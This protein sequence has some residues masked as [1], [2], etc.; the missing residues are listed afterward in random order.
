MTKMKPKIAQTRAA[1][2]R[3]PIEGLFKCDGWPLPG[4]G[5]ERKRDVEA[6]LEIGRHGH[7]ALDN[8]KV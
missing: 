3:S 7:I 5:K 2:V 8:E 1:F 6:C 4:R